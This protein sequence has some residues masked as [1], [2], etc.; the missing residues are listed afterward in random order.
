MVSILTIVTSVTKS[1]T[2]EQRSWDVLD[3]AIALFISHVS[4]KQTRNNYSV[5]LFTKNCTVHH[6]SR[7]VNWVP[8]CLNSCNLAT[9]FFSDT[10]DTIIPAI[11]LCDGYKIT[12]FL[13]LLG[14]VTPRNTSLHHVV[15]GGTELPRYKKRGWN[16]TTNPIDQAQAERR[17]N[18]VWYT[19]TSVG[20]GPHSMQTSKRGL[21]RLHEKNIVSSQDITETFMNW[22]NR[23]CT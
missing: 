2:W 10:I 3:V 14:L 20:P 12:R 19:K 17:N 7:Y 15:S 23:A 21:Q 1:L 9:P 4:Q 16:G 22:Q 11:L 8:S 18:I 6:V 5:E 13:E